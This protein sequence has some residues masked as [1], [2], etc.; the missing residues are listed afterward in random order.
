METNRQ[1][2]TSYNTHA[3]ETEKGMRCVMAFVS[4]NMKEEE[5]TSNG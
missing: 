1:N 2:A 4:S 3:I 5:A